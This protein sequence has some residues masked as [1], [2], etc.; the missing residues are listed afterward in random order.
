MRY[1]LVLLMP[2][3]S[4]VTFGQKI[5]KA[6]LYPVIT[7]IDTKWPK[8]S[9][10]NL[11]F[12][13][14][15][16]GDCQQGTGERLEFRSMIMED[17]KYYLN[18][19][20]YKGL[21]QDQGKVCVGKRYEF[22]LQFTTDA[23]KDLVPI[24]TYDFTNV[25]FLENNYA[26]EGRSVLGRWEGEATT[27]GFA[28]RYP[29]WTAVKTVYADNQLQWMDVRLP[30]AH[31]F[32]SFKGRTYIT[33]DFLC[34]KAELAN[35]DT[36]E[37]FFFRNDFFG[38][39][40]LTTK[41]GKKR[42]GVWQF[43][44]LLVE[45]PIQWQP[46]LTESE[47]PAKA[48]TDYQ[49][50]TYLFNREN[51]NPPFYGGTVQNNIANGWAF[52]TFY[53]GQQVNFMR[54]VVYGQWKDN[55]LDG[56][57]VIIVMPDANQLRYG[58]HNSNSAFNELNYYTG[59][60][61]NGELVNGSRIYTTYNT[62]AN[63]G[64]KDNEMFKLST[65]SIFLYTGKLSTGNMVEGCGTQQKAY[66][67]DQRGRFTGDEII[68]GKFVNGRPTGFYFENDKL[69]TRKLEFLRYSLPYQLTAEIV[70][71][72]END[73]DFC[74]DAIRVLK[75]Q[76]MIALRKK[77]Q[78]DL[79]AIEESKKPPPPFDPYKNLPVESKKPATA[80]DFARV[81]WD[82]LGFKA[83]AEATVEYINFLEQV[84]KDLR[85]YLDER[86]TIR[87]ATYK[88]WERSRQVNLN[89][90]V[91]NVYGGQ[92]LNIAGTNVPIL[93]LHYCERA[94]SD[95][96]AKVVV[97]YEG[98]NLDD[99]KVLSGGSCNMITQCDNKICKTQCTGAF[100]F[101]KYT[102]HFYTLWLERTGNWSQ[103]RMFWVVLKDQTSLIR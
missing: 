93:I 16:S 57:G 97:K 44:S 7:K 15:L 69:R 21:F 72:V 87:G 2:V 61:K 100:E 90:S 9:F 11:S 30:A 56:P 98:K 54:G 79:A 27:P 28:K 94:G 29:E 13:E 40:I 64:L 22:K 78:G 3:I 62:Q 4:Q 25:S 55:K 33:G 10:P 6:A 36:Y 1:L 92:E 99:N 8:S 18:F 48:N 14:C 89:G 102:N 43:D 82:A 24:G 5:S 51:S 31:R 86:I 73:N 37:G 17:N 60:F 68:E 83:P 19:I 65:N 71:S 91:G 26:G 50:K 80:T 85:K 42:A 103:S 53:W 23:K 96:K 47:L 76:F 12:N 32:K 20:L 39:G 88:K 70:N 45:T 101:E 59:I 84:S 34:G 52:S 67:L 35:G 81:D 38:P 75:P 77:L 66:S 58:A 63:M 95:A 74:I 41:T 49:F 46:F